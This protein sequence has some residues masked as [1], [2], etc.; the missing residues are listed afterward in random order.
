MRHAPVQAC[1]SLSPCTPRPHAGSH[2][3]T[4][5]SAIVR[6]QD[7]YH[8]AGLHGARLRRHSGRTPAQALGAQR[9]DA[10]TAL[11]GTSFGGRRRG[12][13]APGAVSY[14]PPFAQRTGAERRH[15]HALAAPDAAARRATAHRCRPAR[16]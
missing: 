16:P 2:T 14:M 5:Q 3:A 15:A 13:E 7:I 6:A 11:T 8:L 1:A 9:A 10:I 4:Q 12:R